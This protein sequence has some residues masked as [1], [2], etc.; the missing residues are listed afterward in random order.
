MAEVLD[1]VSERF[2]ESLCVVQSNRE[3]ALKEAQKFG[4]LLRRH[5]A[6]GQFS[7]RL[8]ASGVRDADLLG[9]SLVVLRFL[10][11]RSSA[12]FAEVLEAL[13][14]CITE[15]HEPVT[16]PILKTLLLCLD[17]FG[18][19][20]GNGSFRWHVPLATAGPAALARAVAGLEALRAEIP[21]PAT[22]DTA[23]PL[24][25]SAAPDRSCSPA[26][27]ESAAP[28]GESV[29]S[30]QQ[31]AEDGE[32]HVD[33]G[34]PSSSGPSTHTVAPESPNT[35]SRPAGSPAHEVL[36]EQTGDD[37]EARATVPE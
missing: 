15:N 17:V 2:F 37:E 33:A 29:L 11:Q 24:S 4:R 12:T 19:P 9:V 14:A 22:A 13:C 3:H 10:Q 30:P 27:L 31:A 28:E 16:P 18:Q 20:D 5:R 21:E 8:L 7:Q 32:G 6:G 25:L 1:P 36:Q 23:V 35:P 26:P 34:G